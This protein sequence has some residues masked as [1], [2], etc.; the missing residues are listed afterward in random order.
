MLFWF[1]LLL[2]DRK[3]REGLYVVLQKKYFMI[4]PSTSQ[5]NS[6]AQNTLQN[7]NNINNSNNN[8]NQQQSQSHTHNANQTHNTTGGMKMQEKLLIVGFHTWRHLIR[9]EGFGNS[10]KPY[11]V[12]VVGQEYPYNSNSLVFDNRKP[13]EINLMRLYK[14]HS[15]MFPRKWEDVLSDRE[16]AYMLEGL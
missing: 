12:S 8:T 16:L 10:Q 9:S 1:L 14:E 13:L 4:N 11:R 2:R 5:S 7:M 15:H 6:N 3:T